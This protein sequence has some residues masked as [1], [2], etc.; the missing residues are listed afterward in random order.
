MPRAPAHARG[1][2]GRTS[3]TLVRTT[4]LLLA[5]VLS[6]ALAPSSHAQNRAVSSEPT[7]PGNPP[8]LGAAAQMDALRAVA[9]RYN[10]RIAVMSARGIS[11]PGIDL[12]IVSGSSVI[13]QA[14]TTGSILFVR[15]P[16][17]RYTI[18]AR[19]QHVEEVRDVQV[20]SRGALD[21]RI[22]WPAAAAPADEL[23]PRQN[24]AP[25]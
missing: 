23:P 21:L 18:R 8:D 6:S 4:C 17:G 5:A 10:L 1:P 9:T 19:D 7:A 14:R 22:A 24:P 11:L 20:P 3:M 2:A 12:D 13:L 16:P 25:H 15:V